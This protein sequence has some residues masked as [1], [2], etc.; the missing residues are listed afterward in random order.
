MK[1]QVF[2]SALGI[3]NSLGNSGREIFENLISG[4]AKN[5]A[6]RDD[7]IDGKTLK[8]GLVVDEL[9]EIKTPFESYNTRCNQLLLAAYLQIEN[10]VAEAIKKYGRERIAVIISSSTSGID[11]GYKIVEH[12]RNQNS[13]NFDYSFIEMGHPAKFLASYLGLNNIFYTISTACSSG[14]KAFLSAQNLLALGLCDAVLVGGSDILCKLAAG[15]FDAMEAVSHTVCNP[16]SRNRDGIMLGEGAALFLMTNEKSP[17]ALLGVGESSDAHHITAPDPSG[18][19]AL[20]AMNQALKQ[21]NLKPQDID[22]INLHG[23][24]TKL[25]DQMESLAVNSLFADQ[26]L[27]SS[28]KA[29]TGHTLGVAGI[30]EAG[31]CWLLLSNL[32]QDYALP[33]HIWDG[34]IDPDLA[35]LNFVK[36]GCKLSAAQLSICLSNSFAF[37]GSN[38]SVIIGRN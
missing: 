14:A 34:A 36:T 31:L 7:F 18:K 23:T 20:M 30:I 28:T 16:F 24:G 4:N 3:I 21:A 9:P 38:A 22:Y 19:G 29:L 11:N 2:L 37:G 10:E 32:N 26:T 35:P 12:C 15:G 17:I 13:K 27:C 5:I 33:P 1:K 8:F 25:N 6:E